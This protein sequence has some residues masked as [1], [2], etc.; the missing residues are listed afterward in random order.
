MS[1][2]LHLVLPGKL[3]Q[4]T[5]GYLY[6][7][8]IV[9]GLR[10]RGVQV[11]VHSLPGPYPLVDQEAIFE[12]DRVL[13]QLPDGA[14]VVIDGLALPGVAGS[15]M[16]E[17]HRLRLAALVH[18]PLS[19]EMGL[20]EA[21]A[22]TLQLIEQGSLARV[23][24][25][26]VTS[27]ATAETLLADFHVT[28]DRLG[29]VE[30]G[31]DRPEPPERPV[32]VGPAAAGPGTDQLNLLCVATVTPRKGH[33]ILVEALSGLAD[34]P[35]RLTC[36]GSTTRDAGA[37]AAVQDAIVRHGLTGRIALMDEL[38]PEAL[39]NQYRDADLFVLPSYYEGYGMALAEALS[40][41]LPIVSS[42][43]G[44]IPTTVPADAG[45]L[46]PPGD[47]AALTEA[48]RS[49][50]TDAELR[51][52]LTTAACA[53]ALKLPTWDDAVDRFAAELVGMEPTLRRSL[54]R[55]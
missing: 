43:A 41:G 53:A 34:L 3:D 4:K 7:A 54:A 37:A 50:L 31:T 47:V 26:I 46:V 21:Q 9:A 18:H 52:R 11:H 44:A 40:H 35:W 20:S 23:Q 38:E 29:V 39:R 51:S 10:A 8:H 55:A 22:R 33:L 30:P 42:K 48:L 27:S 49:I 12:A 19:L 24:R 17:N 6:D 36:I 45:I 2:E 15:L 16:V 1:A 13:A 32:A 28:P 5:G 14:L 25:V